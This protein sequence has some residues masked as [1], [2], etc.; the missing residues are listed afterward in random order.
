MKHFTPDRRAKRLGIAAII[1]AGQLYACL[2]TADLNGRV[3]DPFVVGYCYLEAYWDTV[4][5]PVD[6]DQR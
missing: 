6:L 3:P 1:L 4:A 2:A 5:I